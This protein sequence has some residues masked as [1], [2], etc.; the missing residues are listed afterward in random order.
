[1]LGD[2][3]AEDLLGAGV[4]R[5]ALGEAVRVVDRPVPRCRAGRRPMTA[6]DGDVGRK[7][8]YRLILIIIY[9][10]IDYPD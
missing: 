1:V 8:Y 3:L 6:R 5:G 10:S 9:L 4:G 2:H 7:K